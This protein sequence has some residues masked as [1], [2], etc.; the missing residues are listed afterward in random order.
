MGLER[1]T[2]RYSYPHLTNHSMPSAFP[3]PDQIST[4]MKTK[5][6]GET[7]TAGQTELG[8]TCCSI[9]LPL[10]RW[11]KI[12]RAIVSGCNCGGPDEKSFW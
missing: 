5:D 2:C 10:G 1:L 4:G 9:C 12:K 6:T 7:I 3:K 11:R 8:K